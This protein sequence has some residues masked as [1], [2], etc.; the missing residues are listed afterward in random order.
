VIALLYESNSQRIKVPDF[1]T[2]KTIKQPLSFGRL[3]P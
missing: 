2:V 1:L 3:A